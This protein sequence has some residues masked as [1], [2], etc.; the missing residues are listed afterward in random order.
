MEPHQIINQ[1][2]GIIYDEAIRNEINYALE[3]D[4]YYTYFEGK[5]IDIVEDKKYLEERV[6]KI[7]VEF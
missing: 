7:K 4:M 2:G 3:H 5:R 6:T 1:N